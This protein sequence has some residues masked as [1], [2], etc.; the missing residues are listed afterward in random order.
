MTFD[1]RVKE[2]LD[3]RS[4]AVLATL[5][6][7]GTP[8]TSVTVFPPDDPYRTANIRGT[9]ELIDDPDRTLSV[10]LTRRYLGQ[11]P[12]ADPPGSSRLIGRLTPEHISGFSA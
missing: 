3:A 10:T 12:P 2:L 5:N 4:F 7:D 9:V 1:D 6:P 11:D 8:Q